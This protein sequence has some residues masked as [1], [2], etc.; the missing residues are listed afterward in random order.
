[1]TLPFG[2]LPFHSPTYD[3]PDVVEKLGPGQIR[4]ASYISGLTI[5]EHLAQ[6][7]LIGGGNQVFIQNVNPA[8]IVP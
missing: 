4:L 8:W 2:L 3:G 1:M 6:G 5:E 7:N